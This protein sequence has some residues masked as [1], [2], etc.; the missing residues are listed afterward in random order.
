M[1]TTCAEVEEGSERTG[2]P[3]ASASLGV[4]R[5]GRG[6]SRDTGGVRL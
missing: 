4:E 5:I 3:V 6:L 2:K 1:T